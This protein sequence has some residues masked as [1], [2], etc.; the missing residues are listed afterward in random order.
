MMQP[1]YFP[2]SLSMSF[3]V[4]ASSL[5]AGKLTISYHS[6]TTLST[7]GCTSSIPMTLHCTPTQWRVPGH[8]SR[9]SSVLCMVLV[10]PCSSRTYRSSCGV[11]SSRTASL[12]TSCTG[13]GI[14]TLCSTSTPE[15]AKTALFR[16]TTSVIISFVKLLNFSLHQR[17]QKKM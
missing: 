10:T 13:Y 2:S 9:Q 7:T 17:M 16:A 15:N 5:M 11:V 14:T 12:G 4:H 1:H 6:H 8:T 3:W